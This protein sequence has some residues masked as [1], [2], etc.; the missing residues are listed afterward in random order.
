MKVRRV[1]TGHSTEGKATFVVDEYVAPVTLDLIPGN[2]FHRLWVLIRLP[3]FQM[4][5]RHPSSPTT[6]LR[7]ADSVSACSPFHLTAAPALRQ[8]STSRPPLRSS[9]KSFR[10]WQSILNWTTPA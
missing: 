3:R 2:E 6:S 8:T 4:M 5:G 10:E 1:V 7:W 9:R